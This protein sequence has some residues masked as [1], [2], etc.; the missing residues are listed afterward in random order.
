MFAWDRGDVVDAR[1]AGART[2]KTSRMADFVFHGPDGDVSIH[3]VMVGTGPRVLFFNGSGATLESSARLIE[4]LST[5]ATVL[6]HDQRGLGRTSIPTGPYTMA[7]YASD[8]AALCDHVGWDECTVVGISFGGMVA[9]EF[10]VTF[11]RRVARLVLLCTSAGGSAG[12]SYPLHEL[13]SLT[14]HERE[15][16]ARLLSDS[17]FTS[18]WLA[19]HPIDAAIVREQNERARAS[20]SEE[21]RRGEMLQLQARIGH[22]VADRLHL[23]KAPTLV[24]AGRYDGIAPV[25]NAEQ[26]VS[27][28][29][30]AELRVYEGGHMFVAQDRSAMRDIAAFVT[31]E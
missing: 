21:Q 31:R 19:S 9:Q 27:R 8:G 25:A 30:G 6:A 17:R 18:E 13:A 26:I 12:S 20:K 24:A 22:D 3:H 1:I 2:D 11:P 10:A 14:P 4:A 7:Q 16:K 15:E 5:F 23:V 28:I 29:A